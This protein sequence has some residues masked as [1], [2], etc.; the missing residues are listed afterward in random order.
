MK[1]QSWAWTRSAQVLRDWVNNLKA[2]RDA[3]LVALDELNP[4]WARVASFL[5]VRD[6]YGSALI[7]LWSRGGNPTA[8]V[9]SDPGLGFGGGM[10]LDPSTW[11]PG[12]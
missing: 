11:R 5:Q 7:E 9:L 8:G 10:E 6:V 2:T 12:P 3:A 1:G 4:V